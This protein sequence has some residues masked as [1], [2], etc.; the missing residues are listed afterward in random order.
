MLANEVG[1]S[2]N[3]MQP[4]KNINPSVTT[5]LWL[6]PEKRGRSSKFSCYSYNKIIIL[7]RMTALFFVFNPYTH[8][9]VEKC[10]LRE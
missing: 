2:H 3:V 8:H 7:L 1:W 10:F 4:L 6:Y 5:G 9:V